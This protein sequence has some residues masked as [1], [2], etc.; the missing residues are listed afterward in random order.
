MKKLLKSITDYPITSSLIIISI[1]VYIISFILFG[2]E[3]NVEEAIHFGA[4]NGMLVY[5]YNEYYRIITA[6]FIHFGILHLLMNSYSLNGI[7]KF[8]ESV[9]N[10]I[11]YIIIVLASAISTTGLSYILYLLFEFEAGTLSGGIS[12]VV[13][14]MVGSLLALAIVYK[15]IFSDIFKSLIPNLAIIFLISLVVPNISMSGHIFG[16]IGGF[17][18]SFIILLIKKKKQIVY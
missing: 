2:F 10:R 13:F 4:Y 18:S 17:I 3:M 7:G 6:N 8:I 11:E 15:N 5:Y 12:G 9:F 16:M 14:G 1:A